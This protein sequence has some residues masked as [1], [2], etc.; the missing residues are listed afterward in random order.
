MTNQVIQTSLSSAKKTNG[1][2]ILLLPNDEILFHCSKRKFSVGQFKIRS[3]YCSFSVLQ[4]SGVSN[5]QLKFGV[6][7]T[8]YF[9]TVAVLLTWH[10]GWPNFAS[11]ISFFL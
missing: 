2:N 6:V 10:L 3:I 1:H 4:F 8:Y 9:A 7:E 5:Q 11:V